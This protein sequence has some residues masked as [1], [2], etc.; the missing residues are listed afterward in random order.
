MIFYIVKLISFWF[1]S[2]KVTK[3]NKLGSSYKPREL[4]SSQ[5]MRFIP[6]KKFKIMTVEN[7]LNFFL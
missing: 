1:N 7:L 5:C 2:L 4:D 3:L 6:L